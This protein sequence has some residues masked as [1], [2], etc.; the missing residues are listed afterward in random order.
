MDVSHNS[1]SC[2][3]SH[4]W[5]FLAWIYTLYYIVLSIQMGMLAKMSHQK[6]EIGSTCYVV[7]TVW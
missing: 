4:L 7:I 1:V 5:I 3:E 6:K 2:Y